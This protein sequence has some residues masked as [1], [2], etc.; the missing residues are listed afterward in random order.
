MDT[1]GSASELCRPFTKKGWYV[2]QTLSTQEIRSVRD[3][4]GPEQNAHKKAMSAILALPFM[5][6]WATP[7]SRTFD[8]L[9]NEKLQSQCIV[10]VLLLLL[11]ILFLSWSSL[12]AFLNL[13]LA[14]YCPFLSC[15]LFLNH[16]FYALASYSLITRLTVAGV[17]YRSRGKGNVRCP[18]LSHLLKVIPKV[19]PTSVYRVVLKITLIFIFLVFNRHGWPI[20]LSIL[21]WKIIAFQE[22]QTNI[23]ENPR[24]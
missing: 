2:I 1:R 22:T 18:A 19:G 24:R 11:L 17:F 20:D 16:S 14:H 3:H 12:F 10:T 21:L 13:V 15:L 4:V 9:E 5:S 6:L 7:S 23:W 8:G